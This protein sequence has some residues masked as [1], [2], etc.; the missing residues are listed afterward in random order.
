M[1]FG[2]YRFE[3]VKLYLYSKFRATERGCFLHT[4]PE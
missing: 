1:W 2:I 3:Y 4:S